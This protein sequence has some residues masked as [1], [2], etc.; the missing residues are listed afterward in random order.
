MARKSSRATK[1]RK[2]LNEGMSPKEVAEKLKMKPQTVY[3]IRYQAN[4]KQGIGALDAEAKVVD[5]GVASVPRR[6]G[7]PLKEKVIVVPPQT[8]KQN[9]PA[10]AE[11]PSDVK[12]WGVALVAVVVIAIAIAVLL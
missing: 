1:V 9:A 8:E 3:N 5:G 11:L 12:T 2:L 4:K 6:R 10:Q 7:R